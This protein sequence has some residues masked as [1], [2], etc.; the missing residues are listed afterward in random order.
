MGSEVEVTSRCRF[1]SEEFSIDSF[2]NRLLH[3]IE[4]FLGSC[5][6]LRFEV[7][8]GVIVVDIERG[9]SDGTELRIAQ[10]LEWLGGGVFELAF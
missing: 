6:I 8:I 3:E 2:L 1:F 9:A 5:F 4:L 10:A 7:E